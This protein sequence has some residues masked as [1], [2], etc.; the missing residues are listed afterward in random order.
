MSHKKVGD[1]ITNRITL[2]DGTIEER[3]IA[4]CQTTDRDEAFTG[5]TWCEDHGEIRIQARSAEE[6]ESLKRKYGII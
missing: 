3:V 5:S 4:L 1:L 6:I 2:V